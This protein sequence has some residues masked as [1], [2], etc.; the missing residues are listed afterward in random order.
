MLNSLFQLLR[1]NI[2]YRDT[3]I[4]GYTSHFYNN[5]FW[6]FVDWILAGNRHSFPDT[7]A[8]CLMIPELSLCYLKVIIKIKISE[9]FCPVC[10]AVSFGW[11]VFCSAL[12]WIIL[13]VKQ[14]KNKFRESNIIGIWMNKQRTLHKQNNRVFHKLDEIGNNSNIGIRALLRDFVTE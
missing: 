1:M 4:C 3:V 14:L 9:D 2:S 8:C 6:N 13:I 11:K 12:S 7:C 5:R 10:N